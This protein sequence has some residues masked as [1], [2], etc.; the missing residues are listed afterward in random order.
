MGLVTVVQMRTNTTG[1]ACPKV[2]ARA[3]DPGLE[4]QGLLVWPQGEEKAS[5]WERRRTSLVKWVRVVGRAER[6]GPDQRLSA[7]PGGG[8][9]EPLGSCF[10]GNGG[11]GLA[12]GLPSSFK[13][14]CCN[15]TL[16]IFSRIQLWFIQLVSI[17]NFES[18]N[19][20][21][22][23]VVCGNTGL[24]ILALFVRSSCFKSCPGSLGALQRVWGSGFARLGRDVAGG[25][26]PSRA[27]LPQGQAQEGGAFRSAETGRRDPDP[28]HWLQP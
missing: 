20:V 10:M 14:L 11:R 26:G 25:P 1:P 3:A 15:F 17:P 7:C 13:C 27:R 22:E 6:E 2:Q 28:F 5:G 18:L 4:A 8:G 12:W 24:L 9:G 23:C 16:F 21:E 19:G